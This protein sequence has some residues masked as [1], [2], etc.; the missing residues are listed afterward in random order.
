MF[1]FLVPT[2]K[3]E[4]SPPVKKLIDTLGLDR[5]SIIGTTRERVIIY[6]CRSGTLLN[7]GF[8][9]P[10]ENARGRAA[11]DTSWLNAGRLGDLVTLIE[12]FDEGVRELTKMAEDLKLWSLATRDPPPTYVKGKL[13]L[14]GDAAHPMLPHQGQGGAQALEDAAALGA[15]F[16]K[17]TEPEQVEELLGIYNKV[18]YEH[19][20]TACITSRVSYERRG[21]TLDELRRFIPNV[22][23]EEGNSAY[24]IWDIWDSYPVREVERLLALRS[25]AAS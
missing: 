16:A 25:D 19:T 22:T 11:A 24:N 7:C 23:F 4:K 18:R 6:P 3:A 12:D 14:V 17:A 21:E 20:V 15:V 10:T 2:E 8:V 13:A 9:Y 5:T 1:R